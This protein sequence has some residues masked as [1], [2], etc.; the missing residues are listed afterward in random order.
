MKQDTNKPLMFLV[1][2]TVRQWENYMKSVARSQG[3]PASYR[4]VL[5]YLLRHPG[6]SQKEIAGHRETTT[7][8]I[9]QVVKEME[10]EGLVRKETSEQDQ[11][12]VQLYL[13]PKG[14]ETALAIRSRIRQADEKMAEIL[15]EEKEAQI[16]ELMEE[17]SRII[18]KELPR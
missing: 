6:S 14:T 11:R 13:T 4:V 7:S 18:E 3:I 16:I 2:R 8:A 15:G 1:R 5:I 12:Y 10:R 9:S 17:L